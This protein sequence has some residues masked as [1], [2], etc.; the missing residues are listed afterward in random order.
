MERR[1]HT[2]TWGG[3]SRGETTRSSTGFRRR[4]KE[5]MF[6]YGGSEK[7]EGGKRETLHLFVPLQKDDGKKR[8]GSYVKRGLSR[9]SRGWKKP[10]Y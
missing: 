3:D 6:I 1:T 5:L 7:S 4:K 8:I 2:I 10:V 9:A